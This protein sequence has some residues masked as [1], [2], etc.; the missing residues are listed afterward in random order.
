MTSQPPINPYAPGQPA[1]AL[2][3]ADE[4]LWSTLIHLGGF[5]L[6]FWPAL[7]GYIV[8]KDR[9]PF[10]RAHAATS[11]NFQISIIIYS[12]GLGFLSFITFG[13]GAILF[14]PLSIVTIVFMIMAALAANRGELYTYPLT[15]PFVSSGRVDV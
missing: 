12:I 4:R 2:S 14:L 5:V 3:A 10:V 15:V 7:I 8:L 9:G 11:L 13:I 6:S 1:Q